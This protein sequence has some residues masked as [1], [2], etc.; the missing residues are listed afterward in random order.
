MSTSTEYSAVLPIFRE[1]QQETIDGIPLSELVG[2][3]D[4]PAVAGQMVE[5]IKSAAGLNPTDH[6]LDIGCGCGRIAAAL[7]QHLDPTS[8][9]YGV[10]IVPGLV[11]FAQRHISSHYPNF[12]FLTIDQKNS[13]YDTFRAKGIADISAVS[14]VCGERS[15][16][17]CIATSLFT[18]LTAKDTRNYLSAIQSVLKP[19]GRA[20]VTFFVLDATT[21]ALMQGGHPSFGF[22]H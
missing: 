7:T 17:L 15:I 6:V 3:G 14:E 1:M 5:V 21:R 19:D 10:D 18:H 11:D 16:D 8:R 2:G 9:Y 4:P 12:R 20:V 13:F 22:K